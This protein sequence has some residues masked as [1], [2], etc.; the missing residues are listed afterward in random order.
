MEKENRLNRARERR[1]FTPEK[2]GT[3]KEIKMQT[4]RLSLERRN[5][6]RQMQ[7]EN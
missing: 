2:N 7:L 6:A 1:E 5:Q 4:Q 3:E